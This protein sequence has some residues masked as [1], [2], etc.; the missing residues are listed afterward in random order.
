MLHTDT[1]PEPDQQDWA[2]VGGNIVPQDACYVSQI[3]ILAI[4]LASE[5]LEITL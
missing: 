2:D 1:V 3:L 4:I 5:F